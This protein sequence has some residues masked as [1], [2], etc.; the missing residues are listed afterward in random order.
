[1]KHRTRITIKSSTFR[2]KGRGRGFFT[3]WW[4]W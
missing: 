1:M 2:K 3:R 4:N